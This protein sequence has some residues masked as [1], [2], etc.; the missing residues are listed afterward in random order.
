MKKRRKLIISIISAIAILG[1]GIFVY[2]KFFYDANKLNLVEQEWI[3]DH[4]TS[5]INFNIPNDINV[6]AKTGKGVFYDFLS[7]LEKDDSINFNRNINDKNEVNGLGFVV[8]DKIDAKDLL[9]YTDHY[10]IV[11]REANS[12]RNINDLRGLTIGALASD[13]SKMSANYNNNLTYVTLDTKDNLVTA[14]KNNKVSVILVPLMEYIDEILSNNYKIVYHLDD[15]TTSYYIHLGDEKT[16]NSIVRKY[17]NN[18][19]KNRYETLYYE[20]LYDLFIDKLNITQIDIDSLTNKNYVYGFVNEAPY[21]NLSSS[22]YGGIVPS[23]LE[24]FGKFSKAE[25]TY[26]KFK[27]FSDLLN[28]F[29]KSK[30]DIYFNNTSI[31]NDKI[32]I[33]TDLNDN[34]YIISPLKNFIKK[35]N[36]LDFNNEEVYVIKDSILESVLSKYKNISLKTVKNEKELIKLSK[37]N[38]VIAIPGETYEYYKNKSIINYHIVFSGYND[39]YS[40][41]YQKEDTFSKLFTYFVNFLSPNQMTNNGINT[42]R[43][44]ESN[45][46]LISAIA[47][48]ILLIIAVVIVLIVIVTSSK[49]RIKLNT[50]IKK[51]EKLKFI[52]MLTS[53]KNRNYLNERIKIWNQNT[54]YPQAIIVVDLNNIKYLNDTFGTKEGDK[55]I[56]AAANILH[57]TQLDNTEIMRTDGNEFMIYLVGYAEK[58]VI[59]YMKKLIKE[60]NDLPYEYGAAFGF[61]MIVDDLK[62]IDDAIN[63]AT[64]QMRENKELENEKS[65]DESE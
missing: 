25:F 19:I 31:T 6:F 56:M 26:T 65:K 22:Q 53:L 29:N 44:A 60:F 9:I 28:A 15:M 41:K 64:I 42:Y 46:S 21:Q 2:Y 4:K 52:D 34:Y 17:Y 62:L 38:K 20:N 7:D 45:G 23:Y 51:D 35:S 37:K 3:N 54:I 10:V 30:V 11:S 1:I 36:L 50:K 12:I 63:E 49:K 47:K 48:Y 33:K 27:S 59:N 13:I 39:N 14:L 58:Q 5:L 8:N 16:L 24:E 43:L 61:S 40:F 55:Q 57:Q 18:W 32:S